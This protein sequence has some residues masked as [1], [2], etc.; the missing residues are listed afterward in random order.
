MRRDRTDEYEKR[1]DA[2]TTVKTGSYS[3]LLKRLR[4]QGDG[5]VVS[6]VLAD[7]LEAL[8][9][10]RDE[11]RARE[12]QA[13]KAGY[14]AG[15]QDALVR[16]DMEVHNDPFPFHPAQQEAH[17]WTAKAIRAAI[18]ALKEKTQ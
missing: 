9:R 11:A 5:F 17:Q 7:H 13:Y 18:L 16:C 4:A 8:I 14:N 3:K 1:K 6:S 10:E 15:I 12:K 2:A